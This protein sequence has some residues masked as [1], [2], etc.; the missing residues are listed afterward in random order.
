MIGRANM[1]SK[2]P[3]N[4]GARATTAS[5]ATKKTATSKRAANGA[6]ATP[7]AKRAPGK[8]SAT[9]KRGKGGA[10]GVEQILSEA[11]LTSIADDAFVADLEERLRQRIEEEVDR[12]AGVFI[13]RHP[14]GD[15]VRIEASHEAFPTLLK[16]ASMR[17]NVLLV[18]PSGSS[19]TTSARQVAA[20]LKLD[21]QTISLGPT[22]TETR[23]FGYQDAQGRIVETPFRRV[24]E[25]GGVFVFDEFD[26]ANPLVLNAINSALD[27]GFATFPDKLVERHKDAVFICT[28]NTYGR[29]ADR[30]YVGRNQLDASTLERFATVYW[31]YD[32]ELERALAGDDEWV[33]RVQA[34]RR[35]VAAKGVSHIVSPRASIKGARMLAEG[36]DHEEVEEMVLWKGLDEDLRESILAAMEPAPGVEVVEG[37][38]ARTQ[39]R[40]PD[41]IDQVL[42]RRR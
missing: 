7:A 30:L 42:A 26:N 38:A 13:V 31:D 8:A 24:Y 10:D 39:G 2:T 18:G 20:A 36:F 3:S 1:P 27:A 33:D 41:A 15:P 37:P 22:I 17:E 28:A 21:F 5:K 40:T 11:L 16:L 35:A 4:N 34:V 32:E 29:G 6:K 12:R 23:I 9:G 25:K 14:D 19:K